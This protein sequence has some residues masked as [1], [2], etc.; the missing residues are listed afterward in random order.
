MA[1]APLGQEP[2]LPGPSVLGF[3]ACAAVVRRSAFLDVGGFDDVV[4]FLGEEERVALDL[5]AAGW[6]LAYVPELVVHHHPATA[7]DRRGRAVLA[8]RN[9]VLVAVQRRP[10]SVVARQAAGALRSGA[11]GHAGVR[12]AVRRLPRALRS[13]RRL[14]AAVE[15]A[16]RRLDDPE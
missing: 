11:T 10:W 14:P 4:F 13:R 3:L 15:A 9:R 5:A 16:R 7:R 8:V 1:A 2:D 6:G 12:A